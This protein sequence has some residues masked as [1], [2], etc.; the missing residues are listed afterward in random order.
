M[1]KVVLILAFAVAAAQCQAQLLWKVTGNGI[2][3]PSYLFGTNH[4]APASVLESVNGL[5]EALAAVDEVYGEISLEDLRSAATQSMSALTAPADSTLSCVFSPSEIAEIDSAFTALSGMS[6]SMTAMMEN[7]K[8]VAVTTTLVMMAAQKTVEGYVPGVALDGILLSD[9]AAAGKPVKGLET[10]QLQ[11]DLLFNSSISS[12]AEDLLS[13][14][15]MDGGPEK[16]LEKL[17]DAYAAGDLDRLHEMISDPELGGLSGSDNERLLKNRNEAWV[18]FLIGMLPTTSVLV[19]CGAGHLPGAKG[20]ISLLR[21][22]G[23]SVDPV[24]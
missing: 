18:E 3:N 22:A 13:M 1:K 2:K 9:A 19:V 11:M 21:G 10:L 12:Q 4:I 6:V 23:F 15:R 14:I 24:N 20:L 5:D 16:Q 8:P 7:Y 17:F